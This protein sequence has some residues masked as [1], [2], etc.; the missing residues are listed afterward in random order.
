[1][2]GH[3]GG[4][5][6]PAAVVAAPAVAP[7]AADAIVAPTVTPVDPHL[8][9]R[10]DADGAVYLKTAS[11]ERKIADWQAGDA[12]AGLAHFGRRFDDFSTEIAL[13]EARLASGS[14]DAKATKTQA[15]QL[16]ESIGTLSA[17][18]DLDAAAQRL[19]AVIAD[20]DAAISAASAARAEARARAIAAKEALC[21]EAETL[22]TSTQWK[23]TGDRLKDIVTEWRAIRGIDRKT[24]DA[25][26]KQFSAARD[27]FG[28]RRGQHF[29]KLDAERD[30]VKHAKEK[31]IARAEEL[32]GSSD[33]K[34]T[35]DAMRELMTEW[36]AAGRAARDVEDALWA[37]FRA[38]QDAFF[39]RRSEVFAE[40]DAEQVEN[41]KQKE[42]IIA[43][44]EAVDVS[45]PKAAQN[46]IRELQSRFD[47]IGHV[48]RDSMRRIDDRMR[49]AEQRVRDA[50]DAEWRRGSAESNPFLTAL[51]ER[52]AEAEAKLERARQ[53][54]DAARIAKAEAD[55]AQRRALIPE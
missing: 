4:R 12:E 46:A 38:A 29:A 24:D 16:K 19:D 40:R 31:L 53:S 27:A 54:G 42:A 9:G 25:L 30:T 20:A 55:V 35:A 37:R 5:P 13:L 39:A 33:W 18:G 3:P 21:T 41:Q 8:W 2:P 28:R 44:A 52:L 26:W 17:L 15:A 49:A 22:A 43:E 14:G 23:Q 48:P 11:G 7:A 47:E 32:S 50:V 34:Q 1:M 45:D 6:S 36:K 51:R 10:I